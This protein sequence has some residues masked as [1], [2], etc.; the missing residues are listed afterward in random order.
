[1]HNDAPT[2]HFIESLAVPITYVKEFTEASGRARVCWEGY[3]Y[4]F[5][6]ITPRARAWAHTQHD[7]A[8][9]SSVDR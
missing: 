2:D 9:L 4:P 5:T 1:M 7:R 3:Y 8:G 6:V